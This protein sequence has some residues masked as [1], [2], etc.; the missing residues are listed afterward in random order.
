M[1]GPTPRRTVLTAAIAVAAAAAAPPALA[2][3]RP[4]EDRPADDSSA[5]A[6]DA[7]DEAP[8]DYRSWAGCPEWLTGEAQGTRV[9]EAPAPA[10]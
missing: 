4:A 6:A 9:V 5:A 7:T 2:A 10:S 3:A 1:T 8:V